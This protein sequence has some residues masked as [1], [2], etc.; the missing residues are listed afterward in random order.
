LL[1]GYQPFPQLIRNVRV[2]EV[3]L[4]SHPQ[5]REGDNRMLPEVGC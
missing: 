3:S 2:R 4:G 5:R 1:R